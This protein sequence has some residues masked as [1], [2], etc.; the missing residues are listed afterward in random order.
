MEELYSLV[1]DYE[2]KNSLKIDSRNGEKSQ[3]KHTNCFNLISV[4]FVPIYDPSDFSPILLSILVN[5]CAHLRLMSTAPPLTAPLT[6]ADWARIAK[7][8]VPLREKT[9]IGAKLKA[10]GITVAQAKIFHV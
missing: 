7:V 5:F 3:I 2:H 10:P 6:S 8:N 4:L 1:V 9:T